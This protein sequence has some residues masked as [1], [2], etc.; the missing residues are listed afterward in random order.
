MIRMNFDS[1]F[2]KGGSVFPVGLAEESITAIKIP[3]VSSGTN[4]L[5]ESS[6]IASFETPVML[7]ASSFLAE[8]KN[9]VLSENQSAISNLFH[10][11][12]S[13]PRQHAWISSNISFLRV[14]FMYSTEVRRSH[15]LSKNRGKWMA[16]NGDPSTGSDI[17]C[18][19]GDLNFNTIAGGAP[20]APPA[21]PSVLFIGGGILSLSIIGLSIARISS[22]WTDERSLSL[23]RE[24]LSPALNFV[25]G[26][27]VLI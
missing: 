8:V 3:L 12:I 19:R 14:F 2:K 17:V 11:P 9:A 25:V 10:F 24:D 1:V 13:S 4:P 22:F 20:P 18:I 15:F 5:H 26:G 16:I 27:I 6:S 7:I 21:P 23:L